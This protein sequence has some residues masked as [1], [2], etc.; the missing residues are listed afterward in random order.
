MKF[1]KRFESHS[2]E[3][4]WSEIAPDDSIHKLELIPLS[5]SE[6]AFLEGKNISIHNVIGFNKIPINNYSLTLY[7]R[8][9][10][11]LHKFYLRKHNDEYYTLIHT[12]YSGPADNYNTMTKYYSCDT[13]EGVQQLINY[14]LENDN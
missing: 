2:K 1:I 8:E 5:L 13:F 3:V 7:D 11:Q 4:L 9:N 6:K 14:L 10:Y 12:D